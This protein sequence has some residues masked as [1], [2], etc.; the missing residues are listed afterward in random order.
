MFTHLKASLSCSGTMT[1]PLYVSDFNN[2]PQH[3]P[4]E[5]HAVFITGAKIFRLQMSFASTNGAAIVHN[6]FNMNIRSN[7]GTMSII[8]YFDI[9]TT[10]E[11]VVQ[12]ISNYRRNIAAL[13]K[14]RAFTL[15]FA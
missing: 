11:R 7:L 2:H 9:R 15:A 6:I 3:F 13:T 10:L 12:S 5:E 14:S 1:V 8:E 4:S